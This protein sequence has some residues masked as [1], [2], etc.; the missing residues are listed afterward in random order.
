MGR[1]Q[2]QQLVDEGRQLQE[3]TELIGKREE[4]IND[5]AKPS[6][7]DDKWVFRGKEYSL[8][9]HN[10]EYEVPGLDTVEMT[11]TESQIRSRGIVPLKHW[12]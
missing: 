8:V 4:T 10:S 11:N 12:N 1:S 9:L 6:K 2:V 5:N 7:G 3:L